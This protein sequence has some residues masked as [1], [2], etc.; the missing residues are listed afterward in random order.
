MRLPTVKTNVPPTGWPS[1]DTTCQT[2]RT[3]PAPMSP[4][5]ATRTC[6]SC[7]SL[8]IDS[9]M[10]RPSARTIETCATAGSTGSLN[11][12]RTL[13]GAAVSVL[14]AAGCD[15]TSVTCALATE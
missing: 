12:S 7:G 2:T 8:A 15:E 5:D 4:G 3:V 1:S 14:F 10:L 13:A 6:A 11:S 9:A